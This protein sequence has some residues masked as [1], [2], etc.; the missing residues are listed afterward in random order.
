MQVLKH[1]PLFVNSKLCLCALLHRLAVPCRCVELDAD[2]W[3][4]IDR[5]G[6]TSVHSMVQSV[7]MSEVK[8][9]SALF[10]D[11]ASVVELLPIKLSS[12]TTNGIRYLKTLFIIK[13]LIT[14]SSANIGNNIITAK[15]NLSI[16]LNV[17]GM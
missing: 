2:A 14:V 11:I 9:L 3:R 6:S 12:T 10:V 4:G 8:M 7:L 1:L 17:T 15:R 16:L 13:R 5:D